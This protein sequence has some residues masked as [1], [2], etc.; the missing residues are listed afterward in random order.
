MEEIKHIISLE[1]FKNFTLV[2]DEVLHYEICKFCLPKLNIFA[3]NILK[4]MH[5]L[6]YINDCTNVIN[7]VM[8]CVNIAIKNVI[9]LFDEKNYE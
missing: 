8:K 7:V 1:T 6:V 3:F 9:Y 5:D 4:K 2:I